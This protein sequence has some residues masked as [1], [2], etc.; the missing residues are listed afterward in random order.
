MTSNG[1]VYITMYLIRN[2][3]EILQVLQKHS[4]SDNQASL[5]VCIAILTMLNKLVDI[6]EDRYTIL[7]NDLVPYLHN[8]S[9]SQT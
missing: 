4:V 3:Y 1:R 2:D 8:V 9:Q 7:V 5:G 6:L